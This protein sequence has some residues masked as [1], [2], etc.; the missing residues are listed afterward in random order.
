MQVWK[1]EV[2]YIEDTPVRIIVD[3]D[4]S[5]LKGKLTP[6]WHDEIELDL[7]LKGSVYYIVNGVSYR[8]DQDDIVVVDSGVI[9]SGRCSDG[10]TVE[11]TH[12][13]VM[14]VQINREVFRYA[15]YRIPPF[16][17]FLPKAEN[18]KLR[19]VMARIRTIYR[20]KQEYYELLLNSE[21][22]RMC[23]CLLTEHSDRDETAEP[24]G[25]ATREIKRAIRY[26]E[27][28]SSEK[29]KLEDVADFS[30]YNPSYFSRRFHQFT[31]F[32]F[33][34]YLNRCRAETA[35]RLLLETE[36]NI[37]EISFECGF[38]NVSSFITFFKRQYHET[39]ERYRQG[40]Q[41]KSKK[42]VTNGK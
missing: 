20:Q 42:S 10:S 18:A 37:S 38:P 30:H 13:E 24:S 35:S 14:T 17:V 28:H 12:A 25:H 22:L 27:E 41:A 29:L 1:E 36:K 3:D 39:P 6:H 7:V 2:K 31:G 32:T 4:I 9:H 34:E 23:Y 8:V 21:L 40:S 19:A 15:H 33:N 26:I 16:Q 11:E 5:I